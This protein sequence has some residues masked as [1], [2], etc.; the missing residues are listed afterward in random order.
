MTTQAQNKGVYTSSGL[1]KLNREMVNEQLEKMEQDALSFRVSADVLDD[2]IR[3]NDITTKEASQLREIR[4][5]SKLIKALCQS[6][7]DHIENLP[8]LIS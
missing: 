4:R 7:Q 8:R 2:F 5:A 3:D 1:M 6:V